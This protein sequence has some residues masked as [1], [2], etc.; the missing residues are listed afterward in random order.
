MWWN[1]YHKAGKS[2]IM[3]INAIIIPYPQFKLTKQH[4][5]AMRLWASQHDL[6]KE[7]IEVY[8]L[9]LLLYVKHEIK[10]APQIPFLGSFGIDVQQRTCTSVQEGT[11]IP[12]ASASVASTNLKDNHHNL[13]KLTLR[14]VFHFTF[15]SNKQGRGRDQNH[16]QKKMFCCTPCQTSSFLNHFVGTSNK[17]TN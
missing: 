10:H 8:I 1:T 16:Q 6:T 7:T 14:E 4:P 5:E 11:S 3:C 9:V 12:K 13:N 17:L 15:D 2:W